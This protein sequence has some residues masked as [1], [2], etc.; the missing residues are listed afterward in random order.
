[1]ILKEVKAVVVIKIVNGVSQLVVCI[2]FIRTSAHF[3]SFRVSGEWRLSVF[4][5]NV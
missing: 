2:C 5:L 3:S 4:Q 1:M